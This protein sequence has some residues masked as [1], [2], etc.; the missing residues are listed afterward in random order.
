MDRHLILPIVSL[1]L[2]VAGLV[3]V[4]IGVEV[5]RGSDLM[6]L[7]VV[8]LALLVAG[9][10]GLAG[11]VTAIVALRSKLA[12]PS[13]GLAIAGLVVSAAPMLLLLA[14]GIVVQRNRPS[15]PETP[16]KPEQP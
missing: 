11:V 14:V 9:V 8:I 15:E 3:A 4:L 16:V 13:K 10:L 5:G 6:G 1:G 7:G 12:A 2:G